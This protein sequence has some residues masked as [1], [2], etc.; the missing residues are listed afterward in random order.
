MQQSVILSLRMLRLYLFQTVR[1]RVGSL[2]F[3]RIITPIH[4]SHVM[5]H[6]LRVMCHM[7]GVMCQMSSVTLF[8]LF[9]SDKAVELVHGGSVINGVFAV[10]LIYLIKKNCKLVLKFKRTIKLLPKYKLND[11]RLSF[12]HMFVLFII[13]TL[14]LDSFSIKFFLFYK[15]ILNPTNQ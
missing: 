13:K 15:Q 10:Q 5:C 1:A 14:C 7:S 8:S 11:R 6:M 3:E 4:V 12:I 2:N 9:F